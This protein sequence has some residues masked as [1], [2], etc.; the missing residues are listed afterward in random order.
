MEHAGRDYEDV[1]GHEMI[2]RITYGDIIMI[3]N[4]HDY[5]KCLMPVS[6]EIIE[7]VV[8]PDP[9]GGILV[10]FDEFLRAGQLTIA[11]KVPVYAV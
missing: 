9:A 10:I 11:G 6:R 7:L 4:G 2:F 5:L 3:L 1:F 8:Q